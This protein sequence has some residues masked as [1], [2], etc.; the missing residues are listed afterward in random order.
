MPV[1]SHIIIINVHAATQMWCLGRRFLPLLIEPDNPYWENYL[2]LLGAM[3]H[4]FGHVT[5]ADKADYIMSM[6]VEDFLYEFC[7]L[8]PD[9]RLIPKMHYMVHLGSWIKQ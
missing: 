7:K 4:L 6:L 2:I 3:D 8:Y 1:H 9:R 5:T